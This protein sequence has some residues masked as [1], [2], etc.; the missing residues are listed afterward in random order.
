MTVEQLVSTLEGTWTGLAAACA[1]LSEAEWHLPTDLPGWTVKDNVSH[2]AGLERFFMGEPYPEH[3]LPAELPHVR[4]EAGRF[5]EVLVDVRRSWPGERVLDDLRSMTA[6]R[7][8]TLRALPESALDEETDF[9]FGSRWTW[10]NI[11]E[12][13]VFDS[14]VHEQDVRRAV[15]RPGGLD[16][17]AARVSLRRM[18]RGL[19]RLDSDV[20]ALDGRA[21]LFTTTGALETA[22]TVTYGAAP[23]DPDVRVSLDWETFVRLV[24]GRV[25]YDDVAATVAV[26]GDVALGEELLRHAAVTP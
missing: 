7:L 22:S 24:C 26:S 25:A 16:S 11:L 18:L 15:R 23:A 6:A 17:E 5:M 1:G 8:T 3:E 2:V 4:D 21:V 13:R 10:R 9:L 14:W 12:I 20:P 19:S